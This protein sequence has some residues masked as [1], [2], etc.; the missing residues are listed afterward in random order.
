MVVD[1]VR[2]QPPN[3]HASKSGTDG[4][5]LEV[6][7]RIVGWSFGSRLAGVA[8]ATQELTDVIQVGVARG[9]GSTEEKNVFFQI[10]EWIV[11]A[12]ITPKKVII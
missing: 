5:S 3:D 12:S 1:V 11:G 2:A 8:G 6:A 9:T 4:N 10:E 7:L